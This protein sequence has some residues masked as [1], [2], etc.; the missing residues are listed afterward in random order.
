MENNNHTSL[1][2]LRKLRNAPKINNNEKM[3]LLNELKAMINDYDWFTIGIMAPT[4]KQALEA[5]K[6]LEDYFEWGHI[7]CLNLI[8]INKPVF[9]KANQKS[10]EVYIRAEINLGEGILLTGQSSNFEIGSDT[11]GPLPLNICS[12]KNN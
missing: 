6:E 1:S 4:S 9:L 11:W 10:N 7:D 3:L 12:K 5:L 2:S 8:E